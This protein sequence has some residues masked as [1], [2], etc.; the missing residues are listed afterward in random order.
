MSVVGH[1][2]AFDTNDPPPIHALPGDEGRAESAR[3]NNL[4]G[5]RRSESIYQDELHSI[6]RRVQ[7]RPH[8]NTCSEMDLER[9][10]PFM[11][12]DAGSWLV[13]SPIVVGIVSYVTYCICNKN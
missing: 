2:E 11:G 4:V 12:D 6:N 1:R 5:I 3:W 7:S 9:P 10:Y 8:C 13:S